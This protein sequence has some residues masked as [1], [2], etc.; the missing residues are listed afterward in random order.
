MG[1]ARSAQL[2]GRD[3]ELDVL[4]RAAGEARAGRSRVVL[5]EGGPGVGKDEVGGRAG[6]GAAGLRGPGVVFGHGIDLTGGELACGWW[7]SWF[8]TWRINSAMTASA[9]ISMTRL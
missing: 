4:R 7:P 3:V 2:I 6:P 8:A 1:A 5:V 9:T